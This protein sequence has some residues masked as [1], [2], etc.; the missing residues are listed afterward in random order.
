MCDRTKLEMY[1]DGGDGDV[2]D[3]DGGDG[4]GHIWIP[5]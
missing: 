4:D 3:D 5:L 1:L 2:D